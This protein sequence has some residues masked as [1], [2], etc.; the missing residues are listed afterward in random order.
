MDVRQFRYFVTTAEEGNV[1]RAAERL[2]LSQP[3]LSRQIQIMEECLGAPLFVRTARGVALTQVGELLLKDARAVNQLF[4]QAVERARR[5]GRGE[6]G[7]LDVGA[8]GTVLFN[9]LP[10]LVARLRV[11]SPELKLTVLNAPVE[12]L[13]MGLRQRRLHV[14]FERRQLAEPDIVS[15]VA[16][17]EPA[18]LALAEGHP[19]ARLPAVDIRALE[20]EP[21]IIGRDIGR[22]RGSVE[23]CREH[24]FEPRIGSEAIDST[25]GILLVA[26]GAGSAI[27]PQSMMNL[28]VPGVTYRPLLGLSDTS[29]ELYC[30]HLRDESVPVLTIMLDTL[31]DL[32]AVTADAL[33]VQ[34]GVEGCGTELAGPALAL[35]SCA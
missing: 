22:A 12:Q 34:R 35:R 27:C 6:L 3:A 10:R 17:R 18:I 33:P 11:K 9:F 20:S 26:A 15:M 28:T 31:R 4:D 2:H 24:G 19:L 21:L 13:V 5:A 25:A 32:Q 29:Y 14:A 30:Y 1:G 8:F 7:S 16:G 23:F